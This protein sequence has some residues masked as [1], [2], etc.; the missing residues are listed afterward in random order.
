[1]GPLT[2]AIASRTSFVEERL[3]RLSQGD[4]RATLSTD[5]SSV[6]LERVSGQRRRSKWRVP[7]NL[8]CQHAPQGSARPLRAERKKTDK[9]NL[10][11][12]LLSTPPTSALRHCLG[13]P[14][15]R[16]GSG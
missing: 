16:R 4:H 15:L 10:S 14:Q 12:Y 9:E 6:G 7:L 1:M 3:V 11:G 5:H 2:E 13:F 8:C